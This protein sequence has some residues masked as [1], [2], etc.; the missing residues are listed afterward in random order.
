MTLFVSRSVA[1]HG[2]PSIKPATRL[3]F[4]LDF[5][6]ARQAVETLFFQ[7]CGSCLVDWLDGLRAAGGEGPGT[8]WRYGG[9]GSLMSSATLTWRVR[10]VIARLGRQSSRPRW[11]KPG[12]FVLWHPLEKAAGSSIRLSG[13]L[14][15]S[16]V[17]FDDLSQHLESQR[18]S[19]A[20]GMTGHDVCSTRRPHARGG[21]RHCRDFSG[22]GPYPSVRLPRQADR[23]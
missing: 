11:S 22:I 1:H 8:M 14:S 4:R 23:L 5:L 10:G 12:F 6:H 9:G 7:F 18:R 16:N 13:P 15:K 20:I 3:A 19:F 17:W 21:R 2:S